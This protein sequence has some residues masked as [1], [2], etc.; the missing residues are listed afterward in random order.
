MTSTTIDLLPVVDAVKRATGC[1]N[2]ERLALLLWSVAGRF[3]EVH[4]SYDVEIAAATEAIVY[5][6]GVGTDS[7]EWEELTNWIADTWE[8]GGQHRYTIPA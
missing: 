4:P 1:R 6:T 5:Q 3:E 7:D 8:N 2:P